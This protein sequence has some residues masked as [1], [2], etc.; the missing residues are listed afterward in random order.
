VSPAVV[1]VIPTYR[2]HGEQLFSL[3]DQL[4]EQVEAI[5][6]ADDASPC[7][8]DTLLRHVAA[9]GTLVIRH[10]RNAGIARS[11]NAGLTFARDRGATW[12]LTVDQDSTLDEGHVSALLAAADEAEGALGDGSVGA[13]APGGIADASGALGY[14]VHT[15]R[16]ITLTEE[17]IQTGTLWHVPR[18][19]AAAGFDER[20]GIDAV[21]AAACLALRQAG[22]AIVVVPDRSIGHQIGQGEQVRLL[23]RSVLASGHS[24]DR[25]TTIVRNRLRLF[26]AEFRESPTHALRTLRR[27]AV[28]SALAVS[29]EQDRW[30]KTKATVKGLLPA[31]NR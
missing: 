20:L 12:L 8:S 15:R 5:L 11:L 31:R 3:V 26:P 1:A 6:V 16:G 27:M 30:A 17:V 28:G 10:A 2:P 13:I 9:R 24:P 22:H 19:M 4:H 18:L 21:D 25:R 14:P 29:V 7:T 23:G